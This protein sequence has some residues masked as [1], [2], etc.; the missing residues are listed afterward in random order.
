MINRDI[1]GKLLLWKDN[2][3]RKPLVLKGARQV[4]KSFIVEQFGKAEFQQFHCINF[5]SNKIAHTLFSEERSLDPKEILK[6]LGH[7][8]G[9]TINPKSDLLFFDEIQECPQ[10]INSCKFFH[11]QLPELALIAAGSY[12]G[13][14]QNEVSFPVGKVT[15]LSMFPL[16]FSEF[17]E[18]LNPPLHQEFSNINL[19]SMQ[20]VKPLY[21][22]EFQSML[23]LYT[24]IGG[25][26][27]IVKT[28]IT[29]RAHSGEV[30]ALEQVRKIQL[31]LIQGYTADFA[32]HAGTVNATHIL[33]VFNAVPTQLAKSYD[34][35]VS[36]FKFLGVIPKQK[37][38]EKIRGPLSWLTQS[39]LVIKSKIANDALHPLC[40][41]TEDNRFKLYLFDIGL[42][43]AMLNIPTSVIM[44]DELGS[45]KGFIAENFI[46]Q[47]LFAQ[48]DR[49]LTSWQ[50]A[51]SEIEFL[52]QK[53]NLII[54]IEV[55][56]SKRSTRAKSLHVFIERYS[57][58]LAYKLSGQNY[59]QNPV[60]NLTML[61]LYLVSKI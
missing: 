54:P 22:H 12:L 32:K 1:F 30:E 36:K 38:F 13:L 24:V 17:L 28:F 39:R 53:D 34:E 26:P 2:T 27:E 50:K 5:Q 10:A 44:Q 31:D 56:S 33:H 35:E 46:A 3:N 19:Q 60:K 29:F 6:D 43:N 8:L 42:L 57:P 9:R 37:G 20:T 7:I 41:Y 47:E 58:K 61:P 21:H 52:I 40:A 59:G 55:K 45:Y 49:E 18:A 51:K 23:R 4:G 14:M 11:E 15:F 25:M 48:F 16:T